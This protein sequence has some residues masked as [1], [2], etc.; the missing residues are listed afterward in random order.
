MT[1]RSRI[2]FPVLLGIAT[3]F[4]ISSTMQAYWLSRVSGEVEH[5]RLHLVFLN[6]VYWYVPALLAPVI[7]SLATRYQVHRGKLATFALV[8]IM[9]DVVAALWG[10]ED[11]LGPRAPG[12]RGAVEVLGRRLR[13]QLSGEL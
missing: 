9:S 6:L 2:S 3:A 10:V 8:M 13:A 4:G 5:M 12:L 1:F 7:V 11:L